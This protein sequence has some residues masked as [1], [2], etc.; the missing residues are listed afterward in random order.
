MNRRETYRDRISEDGVR[1]LAALDGTNVRL[2]RLGA[3][4]FQPEP[5][6]DRSLRQPLCGVETDS[7]LGGPGNWTCWWPEERLAEPGAVEVPNTTR[8]SIGKS[9]PTSLA[10]VSLRWSPTLQGSTSTEVNKR[11]FGPKY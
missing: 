8:Q 1:S 7:S 3:L 9:P 2:W 5:C 4:V 6:L 11:L 10:N